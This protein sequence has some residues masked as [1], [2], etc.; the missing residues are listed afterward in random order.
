LC[1]Y[2]VRGRWV[3]TLLDSRIPSGVFA[4]RWDGTRDSGEPSPSG[5]YFCRL[6]TDSRT[7]SRKI[8]RLR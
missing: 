1:I 5:A 8:M 4:A 6:E 3:R 2:D 7:I